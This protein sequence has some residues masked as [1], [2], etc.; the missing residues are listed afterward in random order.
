MPSIMVHPQRVMVCGQCARDKTTTSD[1][2]HPESDK[3][4]N[5]Y[6]SPEGHHPDRNLALER[7]SHLFEH[8]AEKPRLPG[9]VTTGQLV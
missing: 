2:N 6:D 3:L 5:P 7:F 8:R 9:H 1:G 4:E